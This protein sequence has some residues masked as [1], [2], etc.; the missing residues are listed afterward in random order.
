[1]WG[2]SVGLM[3]QRKAITISVGVVSGLS[4][5]LLLASYHYERR[6]NLKRKKVED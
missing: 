4:F 3:L 5:C 2:L 1:M 6:Y